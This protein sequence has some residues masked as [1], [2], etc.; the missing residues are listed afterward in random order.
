[1]STVAKLGYKKCVVPEPAAE[2]LR[3]LDFGGIEVLGCKNLK[4][5]INSVFITS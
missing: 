2:M 1:M 5:V 3:G 4:E